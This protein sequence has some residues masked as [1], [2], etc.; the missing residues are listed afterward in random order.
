MGKP[1]TNI[2][3]VGGGTSGWITAS[4]LIHRYKKRREVIGQDVSITVIESP[5]T[6]I[7]GVGEATVPTLKATLRLAGISEPEFFARTDATF[8]LGILFK[9]WNRDEDG[10]PISYIHPFTGG[11]TVDGMN[12]GYSFKRYGITGRMETT[13][14][15][16]VRT[17]SHARDA[18][19]AGRGPRAINGPHYDGALQYAYHLDAG[20]LAA[21]LAEV[22]QARGVKHVLDKVE[23][24]NFDERGFISSLTL[25]ER[26]DW[27]VELVVDCTGFRGLIINEAMKEPF[28]SFADYLPND[29]AIPIQIPHEDP[30]KIDSVTTSTGLEAGWSWHI[31]LQSRIGT[32]YVYCSAFK[33]DDD[34]KKEFISYLGPRAEGADPRVIKMRVGHTRRSWVKNCVAIG[35]S[36]GFIEPLESTAIMSV[37]LQARWLL[38]NMPTADFEEPLIEQFNSQCRNL[39]AEVRDFLSMHFTQTNREDTPYWRALRYETKKSDLFQSHL[40]L[41]KYAL[42]SPVDPGFTQVFNNWSILCILMG[43]NF[44]KDAD[45]RTIEVVPSVTWQ[46]YC[47]EVWRRKRG[48]LGRIANHRKLVDA[49]VKSAVAGKSNMEQPASTEPAV[50]VGGLS[51]EPQ[52][53]MAQLN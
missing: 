24:V 36:S 23:N 1:I 29:R 20:K 47:D 38:H 22:A 16:F 37:E 51:V 46:K 33:S 32:G 5:D 7:I 28:D 30:E 41:W 26:G 3:I 17:I 44:Y 43:K 15:D 49:L 40:D 10:A 13:D 2:T 18:M 27:P 52:P 31:P 19:E 34:A 53:V 45:L 9:D 42:P 50:Q 35:L 8:K 14:Q 6:G 39:Y 21:F 4:Y 25:K 11:L 48:V 12:P